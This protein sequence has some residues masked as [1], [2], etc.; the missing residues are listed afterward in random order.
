MEPPPPSRYA[1]YAEAL[2]DYYHQRPDIPALYLVREDGFRTE[3]PV[4]LFFSDFESFSVLEKKA[5]ECITGNVLDVGAGAGRHSLVLMQRD[6]PVTSLDIEPS[7]IKIM[8]DRGLKHVVM[9]DIF[10]YVPAE[11]YEFILL[12]L[13]GLGI[14]GNLHGLNR[15]LSHLSTMLKPGG[16]IIADSLD[17]SETNETVHLEYQE[18][19]QREKRYRGEIRMF[20]EYGARK[21]EMIEW[22]HVDFD[23][24]TGIAEKAGLNCVLLGSE[25]SG[26]YLTGLIPDRKV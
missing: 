11:K 21:S 1:L 7:L 18:M 13:H 6:I 22:L 14:A 23:T 3:L 15:L 5:I 2:T 4:N 17:V 25:K 20:M 10:S 19:L 8:V 12:L 26:E 24:L 16:R 9:S